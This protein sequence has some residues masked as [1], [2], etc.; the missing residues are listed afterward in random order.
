MLNF[1]SEWLIFRGPRANFHLWFANSGMGTEMLEVYA[2]NPV[3]L[4]RVKKPWYWNPPKISS[5]PMTLLPT[6]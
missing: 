1:L 5:K 4:D 3:P 6:P 2:C